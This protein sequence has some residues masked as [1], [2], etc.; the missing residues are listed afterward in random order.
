MVGVSCVPGGSAGFRR[1]DRCGARAQ[2]TGS[3]RLTRRLPD[4]RGALTN[5][6]RLQISPTSASGPLPR[7][8]CAATTAIGRALPGSPVCGPLRHAS[9][10][11]LNSSNSSPSEPSSPAKISRRGRTRSRAARGSSPRRYPQP[12]TIEASELDP[13]TQSRVRTVLGYASMDH[14]IEKWINHIPTTP[15]AE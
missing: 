6:S 3:T 12:G 10:R 5:R 9:N 14:V 4:A 15:T 1:R 2:H 13:A 8:S 11:A 7:S